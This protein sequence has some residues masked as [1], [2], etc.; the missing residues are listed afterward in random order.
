MG[1]IPSVSTG[2]LATAAQYNA[3]QAILNTLF[4]GDYTS[5]ALMGGNPF[6]LGTNFSDVNAVIDDVNGKVY[7][8]GTVVDIATRTVTTLPAGFGGYTAAYFDVPYGMT[9]SIRGVYYGNM[10][11]PT[12]TSWYIQIIKAGS[13]LW[14][15]PTFSNPSLTMA[16]PFVSVTGKYLIVMTWSGSSSTPSTMW[17]FEGQP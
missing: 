3:L 6:S 10:V 7:V 5:W 11:T 1:N 4:E 13:V 12:S 2:Q 16:G 14:T 15:S 17:I 8:G 9:Q